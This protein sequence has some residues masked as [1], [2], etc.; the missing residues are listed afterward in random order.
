MVACNA[1]SARIA[2]IASQRA[3]RQW[4]SSSLAARSSEDLRDLRSFHASMHHAS[5]HGSGGGLSAAGGLTRLH[6]DVAA[7]AGQ[8]LESSTGS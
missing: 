4:N 8:V 7:A 3:Y 6:A 5:M 2:A 1:A